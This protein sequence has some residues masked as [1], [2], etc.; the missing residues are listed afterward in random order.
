[1]LDTFTQEKRADG[2]EVKYDPFIMD[3]EILC[4]KCGARDQYE[5]TPDSSLR[6]MMPAD[7]LEELTAFIAG[8]GDKPKLRPHPRVQSFGSIAFGQPMHPLEALERYKKLIAADPENVSLYFRMGS[9]LRTIRRYPQSL[10][11]FRKGF[12]L[13][14]KDPEN[15]LNQAMAEHDF[16]DQTVAKERY[17]ETIRLITTPFT[18]DSYPLVLV[19]T[20]RRGLKLLK[21]G[22]SSPWQLALF[23]DPKSEIEP[24]PSWYK[25]RRRG[26]PKKK[27][28]R[29]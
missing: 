17:E 23:E 11:A 26:R 25:K 28:G 14:T 15:V 6:L 4:P 18:L 3:R 2:K 27:K 5:V 24:K 19:D 13:G 29:R 21:Q 20:A 12:E 7:D 16:G 1:L 10:E 22:K 8:Y 9:L